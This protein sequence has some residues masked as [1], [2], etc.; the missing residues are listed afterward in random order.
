MDIKIIIALHKPYWIPSDP[1]YFPLHVGAEGK[2][3]I[4]FPP[5]NTGENI[6]HKNESFCELTG[7]YWAW[8]NLNAEYIG[9]V[10][11]RRYFSGGKLFG[12]KKERLITKP[13]LEKKLADHDVLLPAPRHYFIETNYSQ[14]AH[15]HHAADLDMTRMILSDKYPEYLDTYDRIMHQ[16]W[17]HRCNM[18]I[19][20]RG[21][22]SAYCTWLFDV[23]FELES[24]LDISSY[25]GNDVRVFGFVGER[26]LDVWLEKNSIRY[27]DIPY[28][29]LENQN[30]ITKGGKFLIRKIRGS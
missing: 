18:F 20:R 29:Y 30:W 13:E 15:A 8:K 7:I 22:L 27:K 6:S 26:L 3:S 28:V 10:H 9:L 1:L 16:T 12:G 19:M 23:L 25:T 17:G 11:Y 24:R 21:I 4:G 2:E 14:Y 5:D